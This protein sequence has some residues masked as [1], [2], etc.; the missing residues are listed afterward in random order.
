MSWEEFPFL[1][2]SELFLLQT[3]DII[4]QLKHVWAWSS[5]GFG[6]VCLCGKV[7]NQEY[8]FF[9]RYGATLILSFFRSQFHY[10]I[11]AFHGMY[12]FHQSRQTYVQKMLVIFFLYAFNFCRICSDVPSFNSDI[13][14]S[15]MFPLYF[16]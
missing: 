15:N 2:F 8:N 12:P 16:S 13:I 1:L 3:F 11:C 9:N 14:L 4:H 6:L 5:F 10:I 7:F